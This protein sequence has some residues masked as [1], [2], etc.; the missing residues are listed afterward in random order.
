MFC[1]FFI[2]TII[3]FAL[4]Y[5]IHFLQMC[6]KFT[7]TSCESRYYLHFISG[8][9][10][11]LI[12]FLN[13]ITLPYFLCV[14]GCSCFMPFRGCCIIKPT[15]HSSSNEL[16]RY[17]T[18]CFIWILGK[19]CSFSCQTVCFLITVVTFMT[20]NPDNF[21]SIVLSNDF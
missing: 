5:E 9:L 6:I 8:E 15:F 19:F 21:D 11:Q 18:S 7:M 12:C 2:V 10:K 16:K 20:R 17:T 13:R 14:F 3:T 4:S 1:S